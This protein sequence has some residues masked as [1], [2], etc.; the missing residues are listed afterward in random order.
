MGQGG[1]YER[2]RPSREGSEHEAC[3]DGE[4]GPGAELFDD[5]IV[6][7]AEHQGGSYDTQDRGQERAGRAEEL[8][9]PED[10]PR[11]DEPAKERLFADARVDGDDKGLLRVELG[12]EQL[13]GRQHALEEGGHFHVPGKALEALAPVH[14]GQGDDQRRDGRA[15]EELDGWRERKQRRAPSQRG[16]E[17]RH[18]RHARV[19][20]EEPLHGE[21]LIERARGVSSF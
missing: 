17:R 7:G 2:S 20:V 3:E 11:L 5:W 15:D 12:A 18:D 16:E 14:D 1:G 8:A 13:G 21:S 4:G 19:E 9:D 10:E 6:K